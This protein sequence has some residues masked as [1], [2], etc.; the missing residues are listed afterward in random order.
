MTDHI[1]K[2][3]PVTIADSEGWIPEEPTDL[4]LAY[5]QENSE[6]YEDDPLDD[7][8]DTILDALCAMRDMASS[9]DF[10]CPTIKQASHSLFKEKMIDS[11]VL[12]GS[13]LVA[14]F[15]QYLGWIVVS[16]IECTVEN[17]VT[18]YQW[19]IDQLEQLD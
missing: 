14:Q 9:G 3:E 5:I 18:Y 1:F 2:D 4:D 12:F 13:E 15:C 6:E 7:L 17:Y 10:D 11:L 16:D 8:M 19:C